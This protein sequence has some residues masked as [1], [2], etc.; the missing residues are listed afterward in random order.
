V[1]RLKSVGLWATLTEDACFQCIKWAGSVQLK[2]PMVVFGAS[3]QF[4][5]RDEVAPQAESGCCFE[6]VLKVRLHARLCELGVT[7]EEGVHHSLVFLQ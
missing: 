7:G 3:Q 5:P 2:P 4:R 6:A 1:P